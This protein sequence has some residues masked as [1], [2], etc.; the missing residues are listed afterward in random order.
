MGPYTGN[1]DYCIPDGN[2]P[3]L[4][5]SCIKRNALMNGDYKLCNKITS[6]AR[7]SYVYNCVTDILIGGKV[8]Y[9][10]AILACRTLPD[11]KDRRRTCLWE[12]SIH[13]LNTT[14][15]TETHDPEGCQETI[16]KELL[17][18]K[19]QRRLKEVKE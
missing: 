11:E 19:G 12:V 13:F 10:D 9:K 14:F 15:C 1:P 16:E 18:E 5:P 2:D 8:N 17:T 4:Y 3:A 6:G 7:E